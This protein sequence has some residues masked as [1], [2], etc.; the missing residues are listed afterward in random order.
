MWNESKSSEFTGKKKIL[1]Q[2]NFMS[3]A[4]NDNEIVLNNKKDMKST[5]L[6]S[7]KSHLNLPQLF[8]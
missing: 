5:P 2:G 3:E 7:R 8:F 6:V 4:Y 1:W